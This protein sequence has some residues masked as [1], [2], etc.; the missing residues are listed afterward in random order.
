MLI[1][2]VHYDGALRNGMTEAEVA[3]RLPA[4]LRRLNPQ[5]GSGGIAPPQTGFSSW[6]REIMKA[7]DPR[8]SKSRRAGAAERAILLAQQ[9]GPPDDA[10]LAFSYYVLGRVALSTDP[11]KALESFLKAGTIYQQRPDTRIQEAHVALQI[12]AFQL[13][14]GRGDIAALLI[15]QNL[16]TVR[17]AQHA[18]LLSLMLL[19]KAEALELQ[20]KRSEAAAVQNEA[21]AWARY[22]FGDARTIRERASEILAISPRSRQDRR[23]L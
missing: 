9:A 22:G 4:I 10:R 17:R 11:D 18:S 13:S 21:L 1:L 5:G 8:A 6:N 2:A 20:N 15:D 19:L 23:P 14:A 3:Q 12:A 16:E 7:T